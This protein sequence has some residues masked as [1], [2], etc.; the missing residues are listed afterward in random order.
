MNPDSGLGNFAGPGNL[1]GAYP[2]G[3]KPGSYPGATAPLGPPLNG[4]LDRVVSGSQTLLFADCGTRPFVSVGNALDRVD[5]LVYTTNYMAN[6]GAIGDADREPLL[7]TLAGIMDTSWLRGRVPLERHDPDAVNATSADEGEGGQINISFVDG[8]A[9]S[10]KRGEFD[11][12][13]V[14]PYAL[15]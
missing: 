13:K 11:K 2:G 1:I 6:N 10:V 3:P 4:R 8:H 5:I 12:V 15:K 9:E 14:T 7:G